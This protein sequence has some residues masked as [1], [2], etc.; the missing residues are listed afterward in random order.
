MEVSEDGTIWFIEDIS[1]S[2]I[3]F[4]PAKNEFLK[5]KASF[6]TKPFDLAI[7]ENSDVWFAE[8]NINKIG[9][10][11]SAKCTSSDNIIKYEL[12]N[13]KF[14][15]GL[16]VRKGIV[17]MTTSGKKLVS[18]NPLTN[19]VKEYQLPIPK[20]ISLA[21]NKDNEAWIGFASSNIVARLDLTTNIIELFP[22][23]PHSK[24][25]TP[26]SFN[27]D[28][29]G[30]LWF[31]EPFGRKVGILDP[32]NNRLVEIAFN[33][34]SFTIHLAIDKLGMGYISVPFENKIIKL[35][36]D[37]ITYFSFTL[38]PISVTTK[39]GDTLSFKVNLNDIK[40]NW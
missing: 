14:I 3:C 26:Y 17:W 6:E 38:N 32:K 11:P 2:I 28:P 16:D 40:N 24:G 25:E 18:F 37:K 35:E 39:P 9:R 36:S 4:K 1:N 34:T 20:P 15:R 31:L 8:Y 5:I 27:I 10:I 23:I 33:A 7:D 30:R 19:E 22:V 29:K 13:I 21:I 12:P